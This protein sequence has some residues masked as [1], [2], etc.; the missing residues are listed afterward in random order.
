MLGRKLVYPV[1]FDKMEIDFS[2][3]ELTT[4]LVQKL[5]EIHSK[6]FDLAHRRIL[7]AQKRYST[8]YNKSNNTKKFNLKKGT[9]VQYFRYKSKRTL[10]ED[11]LSP[12]TPMQ[13]YLLIFAIDADR[14]RVTLQTTSGRVL[15]KTHPFDRIHKYLGK[16]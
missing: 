16:L 9:A 4:P 14:K 3:V 8:R 12:W 15:K 5:N 1:E 7:K 2:G 11:K 10:S 6:N 13:G